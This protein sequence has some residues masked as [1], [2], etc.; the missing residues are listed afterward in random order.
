MN[1]GMQLD[2]EPDELAL[3]VQLL[4][5]SDLR[6]PVSMAKTVGRLQDKLTALSKEGDDGGR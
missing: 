6:L 4:C 1:E 3:L 2:L 5:M